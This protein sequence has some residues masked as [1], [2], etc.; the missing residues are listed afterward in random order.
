MYC[1]YCGTEID[2]DSVYCKKCGKKVSSTIK[3]K[4]DQI[5]QPSERS[6]IKADTYQQIF[7]EKPSYPATKPATR[8]GKPAEIPERCVALLIDD[9]IA[10]A[11][12]CFG[13]IYSWFKDA[14]REGQS[15][16]K[17]FMG[18]RVVDFQT[19]VPASFEQSFLRNCCPG[20]LDG[21]CCYLTVLLDEN[22]RR[23]GDHAAGT[24]VIQDQ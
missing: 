2:P 21:C 6:A 8:V 24:I 3:D 12:P 4:Y 7:P 23:I 18:L 14:L 11:I 17:G 10:S 5:F 1:Q 16:G 9:C 13:F 20:C 15:V 22:S 19:G